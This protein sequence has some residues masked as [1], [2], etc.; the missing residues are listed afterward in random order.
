MP[1]APDLPVLAAAAAV[2]FGAA[3]VRGFAGLGFSLLAITGLSLF[4]PPARVVAAAFLLDLVAGARLAPAA[5]RAAHWPSLRPLLSGAAAGTPVGMAA[6]ARLPEGPMALALGVFVTVGALLLLGGFR[7]RS[8]PGPGAA[9]AAGAVAGACNGAFGI[10]GPPVFML[11]LSSPAGA[12][13]SR[14]TLIA[15]FLMMDVIALPALFAWGLLDRAALI[16]AA[17]L[18]PALLAGVAIGARLSA[19][20]DPERWRT[21]ILRLVLA[22]GLIATVKAARDRAR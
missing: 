12:A 17:A 13:M 14:A 15:C 20:A 22:L 21:A 6:L 8:M 18:A 4:L 10:G 3:I 16:L 9:L 1:E 7:L 11:Y 19:S 2:V 5:W